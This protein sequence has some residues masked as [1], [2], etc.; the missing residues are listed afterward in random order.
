MKALLQ[1]LWGHPANVV[2]GARNY[3]CAD[4]PGGAGINRRSLSSWGT[5][6]VVVGVSLVVILV[7]T[8]ATL[9]WRKR[10]RRRRDETPEERYWHLVSHLRRRSRS[11]RGRSDGA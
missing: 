6:A 2:R 8:A 11:R 3:L 1:G 5:A 4:V 9:A 7:I 10:V